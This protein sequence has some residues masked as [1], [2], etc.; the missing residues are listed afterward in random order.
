MTRTL[1]SAVF[2]LTLAGCGPANRD[3]TPNPAL[4]VPDIPP[5]GPGTKA[6]ALTPA[7]KK[8]R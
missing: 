6:A 3:A 2:V 8:P 7:V 5:A 4:K 1:L